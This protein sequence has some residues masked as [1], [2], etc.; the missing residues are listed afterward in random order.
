[1]MDVYKIAPMTGAGPL[2]PIGTLFHLC[3]SYRESVKHGQ[4]CR[5]F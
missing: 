4:A 3:Q 2:R 5:P 1:M